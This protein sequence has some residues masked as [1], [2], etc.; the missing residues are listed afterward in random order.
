[1]KGDC[2]CIVVVV[3]SSVYIGRSNGKRHRWSRV[4]MVFGTVAR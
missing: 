1:M 3:A 2:C 4:W